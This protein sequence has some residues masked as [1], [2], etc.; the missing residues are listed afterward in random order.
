MLEVGRHMNVGQGE[1]IYFLR[2]LLCV[3]PL[4]WKPKCCPVWCELG[5]ACDT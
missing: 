3:G 2:G 4:P 5:R 1:F